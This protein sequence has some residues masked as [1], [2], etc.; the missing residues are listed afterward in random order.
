MISWKSDIHAE[1]LCF[2]NLFLLFKRGE[3]LIGP[4]V[5]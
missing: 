1:N 4:F 5:G 3:T 2:D